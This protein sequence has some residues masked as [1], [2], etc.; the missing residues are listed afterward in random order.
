VR[1]LSRLVRANP[2]PRADFLS[3][4]EQGVTP[5]RPLTP[6]QMRV[7]SGVAGTETRAQARARAAASP[8]LGAFIAGSRG[9][10]SER[11]QYRLG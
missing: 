8:Q 2:P 3:H 9:R 11:A 7:W 4:A 1:R 5:L 10:G 6:T